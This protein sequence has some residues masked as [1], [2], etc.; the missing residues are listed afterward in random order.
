[1]TKAKSLTAL[2][3]FLLTIGVSQAQNLVPNPGFEH[4]TEAFCGIQF[5]NAFNQATID[6]MSPTWGSPQLFFT[7]IADSCY[8]LQPTN[9]YTGPI[10]IK[11]SQM[12]RTGNVMASIYAYTIPDFNQRS[13]LQVELTSPLIP[14]NAYVVEFFVSLADS[15]EISVDKLGAYLSTN[16][17]SALNNLYMDYT[18][19]VLSD[20]FLDDTSNWIS[21]SDTIVAQDAYSYLTIG[22]F[23][24]DDSTNT[25]ANPLS[26]GGVGA[27][28]AFY[29]VDDVR[30]EEVNLVGLETLAAKDIYTVYPN[31]SVSDIHIDMKANML[32][33]GEFS[34]EMCDALGRT[35][36]TTPLNE[37]TSLV[38]IKR[39]DLKSGVYFLRI[40]GDSMVSKA[41]KVVLE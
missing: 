19:Q 22:N 30:I 38:T 37:R 29:F 12:P 20:G 40:V 2:L 41:A 21:V 18:P 28:G 17:I 1:M 11:G 4:Y 10:G 39:G 15:M 14:G 34:L 13:Y 26:S 6:W 31:P 9:Q 8:N 36:H 25:Q 23:Y 16:Q 24:S 33:A 27:Y 7:N 35:V 32:P 3:L 5:S